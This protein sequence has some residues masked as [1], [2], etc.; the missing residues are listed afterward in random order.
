M[1][2]LND[3]VKLRVIDIKTGTWIKSYIFVGSVPDN[4]K[5]ELICIEENKKY[6]KKIINE[7]FGD[8]WIDNIGFN[9]KGGEEIDL[10][11]ILD[12]NIMDEIGEIDLDMIV[13]NEEKIKVKIE[14]N[15]DFEFV[16]DFNAYP[17]DD[18]FKFKQ[19]IFAITDI[20]VYRQHLWFKT[21]ISYPASYN[22]IMGN[23]NE[24][25]NA[26]KLI[27]YYKGNLKS[28]V[29]ENIP[30]DMVYYKNRDS[31]KILANDTFNLLE[32]IY[33]KYGTNEYFVFDLNSVFE[34]KITKTH[35]A[36][37]YFK[38]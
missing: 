16:F 25:V 37:V 34:N 35:V 8:E 4:I 36:G 14:K 31:I 7:Y 2:F 17:I 21:N 3:P 13:S 24:Y 38:T 15:K 19:K 18:I 26:E 27:A 33:K 1:L 11:G 30:V 23:H 20:P 22:L 29:I 9:V 6:N 28:D 10:D 5:E 12:S 32:N